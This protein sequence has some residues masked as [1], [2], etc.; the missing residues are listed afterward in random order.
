MNDT[1]IYIR[2]EHS[3]TDLEVSLF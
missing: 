3:T 2:R 1:H